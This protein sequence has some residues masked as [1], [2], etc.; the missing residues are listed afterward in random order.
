MPIQSLQQAI[1]CQAEV[2]R[3]LAKNGIKD[4]VGGYGE[5]LVSHALGGVRQN[6]VN[7]GFDIKNR[8]YG[9]IEVKTRK[10]ELK[11]DGSVRKENRAVGFEGKKNG[12]DHLAHVVLNVDFSVVSACLVSYDQVWPEIE[13]TSGKVGFATSSRLPSSKIITDML[14]KSQSELGYGI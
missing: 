4:L 2:V 11:E 9:R 1:A 12:F 13:R 10:Y 3:F 5:L 6:S 14:R 8:E 7:P